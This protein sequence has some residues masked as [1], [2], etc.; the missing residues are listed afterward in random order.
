ML[1]IITIRFQISGGEQKWAVLHKTQ[2]FNDFP[3]CF[4]YTAGGRD[5]TRG[6]NTQKNNNNVTPRARACLPRGPHSNKL[7]PQV[8]RPGG[9]YKP[10]G[11]CN[12]NAKKTR[13]SF[14]SHRIAWRGVAW[15]RVWE[16]Y[17]GS[18][19]TSAVWGAVS[20]SNNSS[21]LS[22]ERG[23][24]GSACI[25]ERRNTRSFYLLCALLFRFFVLFKKQQT[26][27]QTNLLY[28]ITPRL[29]LSICLWLPHSPS[30]SLPAED[31]RVRVCW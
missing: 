28:D 10:A 22:G 17:N 4:V 30:A 26:S 12:R 29:H 20:V 18:E 31:T 2:L 6:R 16:H 1:R 3:S 24:R 23:A 7:V 5:V 15:R 14:A 25:S 11:V 19:C 27:K 13:R 9:I 21:T 8:A